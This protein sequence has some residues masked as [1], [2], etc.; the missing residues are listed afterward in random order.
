MLNSLLNIHHFKQANH[1]YIAVSC[2][3][4]KQYLKIKSPIVDTN[5][6][7][8]QVLPAFNSLN[9]GLSLEFYSIDYFPDY[10]P[11]IQ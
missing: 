2:L 10:F 3:T 8:N 6:H 7:V 1:H 5:N 4:S 11:F 9:K